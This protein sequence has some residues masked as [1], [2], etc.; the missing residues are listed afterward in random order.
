[1]AATRPLIFQLYVTFQKSGQL[2]A[3]ALAD[4]GV[5]P[6]DAPLFNVLTVEAR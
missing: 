1:M 6:E 4:T 5:R 2:V 3:E